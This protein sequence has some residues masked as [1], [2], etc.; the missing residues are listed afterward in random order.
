MRNA[1]ET[2]YFRDSFRKHCFDISISRPPALQVLISRWGERV[3][4]FG[5]GRFITVELHI[6]IN[7]H[8]DEI[9]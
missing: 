7:T 1:A 6:R 8:M 5:G 2:S 9:A 4:E 3:M